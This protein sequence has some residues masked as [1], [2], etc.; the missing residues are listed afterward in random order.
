MAFAKKVIVTLCVLVTWAV[1]SASAFAGVGVCP[2]VVDL[3]IKDGTKA[4]TVKVSDLGARYQDY[5][6]STDMESRTGMFSE[7]YAN[8][9]LNTCGAP[10]L[11]SSTP[12][13]ITVI[14][15]NG[16]KES[17]FHGLVD[18]SVGNYAIPGTQMG[19][20]GFNVCP[21]LNQTPPESTGG[22]SGGSTGGGGVAGGGG[23][24][25][26][27]ASGYCVK[28][29]TQQGGVTVGVDYSCYINHIGMHFRKLPT[30][31]PREFLYTRQPYSD[32]SSGVLDRMT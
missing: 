20:N 28:T 26:L 3:V 12:A 14:Y 29:V 17:F 10:C 1:Y 11:A 16:A 25:T 27:P 23:A 8:A 15:T 31:G 30:D 13:V 2:E 4:L 19:P 21:L 6:L 22:S 5:T 18:S 7:A 32:L 24:S 9:M